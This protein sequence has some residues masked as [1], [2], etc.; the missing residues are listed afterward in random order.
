MKLLSINIEGSKHLDAVLHFIEEEQADVV[1]LQE[2]QQHTLHLFAECGYETNFLPLTQ[3][4]IENKVAIEGVA[5]C[6]RFPLKNTGHYIYHGDQTT[7]PVFD[8]AHIIKAYRNAILH[9]EVMHNGN[10]YT[11]ATTHFT[12][13]PDGSIASEEQIES[14]RKLRAYTETLPAHIICGD[15]NIPRNYNSLYSELLKSYKDEIPLK[16]TSSLDKVIHR[17]GGDA[18]KEIL[19]SSFMVDY[20]FT[21]AP[22]IARDVRLVFGLSDHAGVVGNIEVVG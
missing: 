16:Y 7:V 12:W 13:N 1:C 14:M 17:H 6:S 8:D 9:G 22:Y 15:F 19:F 10:T 5:I 4:A 3:R 21:Q 20:I 2:V 11:I 18:D